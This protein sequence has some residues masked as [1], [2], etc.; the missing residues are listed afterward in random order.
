MYAKRCTISCFSSVL[1]NI[2]NIEIFISQSAVH[3]MQFLSFFQPL[4]KR[5]EKTTKLSK[6]VGIF[7]FRKML[8]TCPAMALCP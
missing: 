8:L 1:A 3:V 6:M 4:L 5:Q 2:Y 7:T